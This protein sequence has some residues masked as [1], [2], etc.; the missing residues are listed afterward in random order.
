MASSPATP[1]SATPIMPPKCPSLY[2]QVDYYDGKNIRIAETRRRSH[3]IW[4][5]ASTSPTPNARPTHKAPQAISRPTSSTLPTSHPVVVQVSGERDREVEKHV[6]SKPPRSKVV[7][8]QAP[9]P[10]KCDNYVA[11]P[12]GPIVDVLT[13]P[14]TPKI[15]RLPTPELDDLDE[16]PFCHCCIEAR[17]VKFCASCGHELSSRRP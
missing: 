13:P 4:P 15:S 5:E 16:R 8:V 1:Q 12:Q 6:T 9:I 11:V 2:R 3:V 7:I 17:V 10:V 14:Q